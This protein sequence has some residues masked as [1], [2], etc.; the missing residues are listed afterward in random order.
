MDDCI[1]CRIIAG[2]I[3]S[4]RV[5]EDGDIVAFWDVNPQAPVHI[6]VVPI[7][8]PTINSDL[9][10]ILFL[11]TRTRYARKARLPSGW[12]ALRNRRTCYDY[13]DSGTLSPDFPDPVQKP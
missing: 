11:P 5:Y 12:H 9:A 6:L 7:S 13:P 2:E 10:I 3:P 1:F 8:S 4:K